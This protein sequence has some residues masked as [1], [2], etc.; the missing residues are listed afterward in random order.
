M[1]SATAILLAIVFMTAM[2]P[3]A[4]QSFSYNKPLHLGQQN[5]RSQTYY[6]Y[7][8]L[9]INAFRASGAANYVAGY[10][11]VGQSPF[12]VPGWGNN[13]GYNNHIRI[14]NALD[15][16]YYRYPY[17]F[18]PSNLNNRARHAPIYNGPRP[19]YS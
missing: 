11:N 19:I 8:Q 14:G 15:H 16:T 12:L 13:Q 3:Y 5:Y 10:G 18:Y 2:L 4:T 9:P 7:P 1:K 6:S 17:L